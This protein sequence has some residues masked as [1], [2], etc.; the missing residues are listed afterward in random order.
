[1]PA[2]IWGTNN[3]YY[4]TTW[5]QWISSFASM[6]GFALPVFAF[7][8]RCLP[9][10]KTIENKLS[11]GKMICYFLISYFI[12]YAGNIIGTVM[13]LS[14]SGGRAQNQ[15][16]QLETDTNP[17]KVVVMV[18]MAPLFEELIFRKLMLDRISKYGEKKAVILTAFAF[19]L[20]HQN[21]SNF[22]MHL[23]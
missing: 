23:A 2:L 1:M 5:G 10:E 17:L 21:L 9:K 15:V 18:I 22:S 7:I 6:Y 14:F 11:V 12:I 13:A 16:A 4:N 3:W 8:M 19:G 20:L